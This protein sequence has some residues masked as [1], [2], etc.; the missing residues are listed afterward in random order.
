MKNASVDEQELSMR[1]S[2]VDFYGKVDKMC[3]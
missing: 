1:F 2:Q 3:I